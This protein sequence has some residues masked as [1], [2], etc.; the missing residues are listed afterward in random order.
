[1]INEP[2]PD[3]PPEYLVAHV[4]EALAT[5]P[6]VNEL[7]LDVQVAGADVVVTG[8]VLSS[9][10]RDAIGAVVAEVAPGHHVRNQAT[11]AEY[12]EP[13]PPAER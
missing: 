3:D 9:E 11:V 10:R 6:R 5:D 8:A 1:M 13:T 2:R 4:R 7:G 12:P